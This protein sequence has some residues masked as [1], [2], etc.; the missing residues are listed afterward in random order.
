[1]Y[2]KSKK[3]DNFD[4]QDFQADILGSIIGSILKIEIKW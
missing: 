4:H 1:M 3:N 2:D